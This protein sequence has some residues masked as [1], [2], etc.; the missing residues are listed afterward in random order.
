MDSFGADGDGVGGFSKV[1]DVASIG[2]VAILDL[3]V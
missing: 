1:V 2:S 3:T